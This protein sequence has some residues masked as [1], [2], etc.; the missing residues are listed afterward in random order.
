MLCHEVSLGVLCDFVTIIPCLN[1]LL[2]ELCKHSFSHFVH[3]L[4]QMLSFPDAGRPFGLRRGVN[5][6]VEDSDKLVDW[7]LITLMQN[8]SSR[9]NVLP[10]VPSTANNQKIRQLIR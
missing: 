5:K 10:K 3:A 8:E 2:N 7:S 1:E 9:E 4:F 6:P